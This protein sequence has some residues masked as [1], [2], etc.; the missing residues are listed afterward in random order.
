[1]IS[2]F[3]GLAPAAGFYEHGKEISGCIKDW[4]FTVTVKVLLHGIRLHF[5]TERTGK[6]C[7][8]ALRAVTPC[9]CGNISDRRM[10]HVG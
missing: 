7:G 8:N 5:K 3:S 1:M 4:K 6:V 9:R 10:L 2:N